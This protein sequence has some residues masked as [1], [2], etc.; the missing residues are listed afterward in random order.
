MNPEEMQLLQNMSAKIAQ[1]EANNAKLSKA[2]TMFTDTESDNLVKWQF[3][4]DKSLL[5]IERLLRKQV[6]KRDQ[7]TKEVYYEDCKENELFNEYGINEIMNLLS[8]Y[9]NKELMLTCYTE[10]QIN[11]IMEQFGY[12]LADFLYYNM[13]K[14]GLNTEDKK[15]HYPMV[16]MNIVNIVDATYRKSLDGLTLESLKTAR[17]VNQTEPLGKMPSY[18]SIHK[19]NFN[20]FKP[21]TWKA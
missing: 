21:T 6:P 15:K 2:V 13:E 5:R 3:D 12:E 11:L 1:S 8:W 10:E 17:I 7:E 19:K 14:F 4:I 16:W 9:V 18:P 20:I